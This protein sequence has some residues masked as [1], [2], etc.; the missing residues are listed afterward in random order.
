LIQPSIWHLLSVL[1]FMMLVGSYK[2]GPLMTGRF[3][4]LCTSVL[5]ILILAKKFFLLFVKFSKFKNLHFS[6]QYIHTCLSAVKNQRKVEVTYIQSLPRP[7]WAVYKLIVVPTGKKCLVLAMLHSFLCDVGTKFLPSPLF[8]KCPLQANSI[9][10]PPHP[11]VSYS[12][13]CFWQYLMVYLFWSDGEN[14]TNFGCSCKPRA[15]S[16]TLSFNT[17]TVK[18]TTQRIA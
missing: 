12:R 18:M 13:F 9:N 5:E 17:G 7:L 2:P 16:T 6:L 3:R 1:A 10:A 8:K 11:L 15:N 14:R 4:Y